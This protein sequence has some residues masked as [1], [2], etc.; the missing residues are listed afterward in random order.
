M[1]ITLSFSKN[2]K[3]NFGA[4]QS[5]TGPLGA[6]IVNLSGGALTGGVTSNL[7]GWNE[8]VQVNVADG[9]FAGK[10]GNES[11]ISL[12]TVTGSTLTG[13]IFA[14]RETLWY[15]A[16]NATDAITRVMGT[17][18]IGWM[19]NDVGPGVVLSELI[20]AQAGA[21]VTGVAANTLTSAIGMKIKNQISGGTIPASN[22]G[23]KIEDITGGTANYAIKTGL[24]L[25]SLGGS[26]SAG[27]DTSG[28]LF[29]GSSRFQKGT[30]SAVVRVAGGSNELFQ[31]GPTAA[32][33]LNLSVGCGAANTVLGSF[34]SSFSA[35]A[36]EFYTGTTAILAMSL[37]ATG[38]MKH[39]AINESTGAGS[40]ALGANCPA[41][42]LTAP[43]KWIKMLTSDGSTVYVPAWK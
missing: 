20:G 11:T 13:D 12:G 43:Y 25:V 18:A 2:V 26:I 40:A 21:K 23:L 29:I 32:G 36:I 39:V 8:S 37:T 17:D 41:V 31:V 16:N 14:N 10:I 9:A 27:D 38:Q 30:N 6:A 7:L 15:T 22:Y 1:G 33:I 5:I 19:E 34:I 35:G 28:H 24:G 3:N 42:T 4:G